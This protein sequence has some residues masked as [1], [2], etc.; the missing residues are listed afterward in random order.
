MQ[1][2]SVERISLAFGAKFGLLRC[3]IP[4]NCPFD[5]WRKLSAVV[6]LVVPKNKWLIRLKM[7]ICPMFKTWIK[8]ILVSLLLILVLPACDGYNKV[9][10][11]TDL[12]YK[13]KK[14]L[15]YYNEGKYYKAYPLI[16]ELVAIYR[17]QKRSEKL[18]YLYAY[19]DFYLEDYLLASHRFEEFTKTFPTSKY[20]EECAFMSAYCKY[21]MSP[22]FSLDQTNTYE[23]I[24][25]LQLFIDRYPQSSRV[26]SCNKLIHELEMKL[27]KKYY[28]GARQY[29]KMRQYNAAVVTYNNILNDFP[30][31]KY[32]EQI[33][34][35]IF[36]AKYELV[37]RSVDEKKLER[38]K[39][40]K[41]AYVN[42]VDR[43]PQS[44]LI[45]EAETYYKHLEEIKKKLT[46]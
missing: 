20:T 14:A 3:A 23:A 5:V 8:Y 34:F 9:L 37:T 36:R 16:E 15:E 24:G 40:A 4:G 35:D 22:K 10:K 38:I 6:C 43:F 41:E 2:I 39:D 26:D 44:K 45:K 46:S 21:K 1:K 13:Y 27:E 17:G 31:T 18:Y 42:F 33:Y 11:S 19:C 7:Y 25:G 32:K 30:D 28:E 12:D 29:L